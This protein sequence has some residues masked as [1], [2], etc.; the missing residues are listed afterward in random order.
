MSTLPLRGAAY[1][2]QDPFKAVI[3]DAAGVLGASSCS[4]G[5]KRGESCRR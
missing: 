2:T 1:V 4:A 5:S 3:Y